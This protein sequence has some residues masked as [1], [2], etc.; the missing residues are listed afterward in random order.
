MAKILIFSGG[1]GSIN[2]IKSLKKIDDKFFINSLVNT[3]DD[4][5]S[6]GIIRD[7]FD[8]PGPS[9]IRKIQEINLE[10]ENTNYKLFKKLFSKRINLSYL[11]F[12]LH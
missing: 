6:S 3:Y 7:I 11:K 10:R 8:I 12:L 1:R 9:D 5:K 4:G 2:L